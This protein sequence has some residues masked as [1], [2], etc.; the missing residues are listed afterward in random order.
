MKKLSL[1]MLVLSLLPVIGVSAYAS[2]NI[3]TSNNNQEINTNENEAINQESN[4]GNQEGESSDKDVNNGENSLSDDVQSSNQYDDPS[5]ATLSSTNFLI[6][7]SEIPPVDDI[8]DQVDPGYECL[9]QLGTTELVKKYGNV[10]ALNEKG[11]PGNWEYQPKLTVLLGGQEGADNTINGIGTF[12]V[13]FVLI[14][15]DDQGVELWGDSGD[16]RITVVPDSVALDQSHLAGLETKTD[17]VEL[18]TTELE[19]RMGNWN[20]E[21]SVSSIKYDANKMVTDLFG[22]KVIGAGNPS[23][24]SNL[25]FAVTNTSDLDGI[26]NSQIGEYKIDVALGLTRNNQVVKTL[27]LVVKEPVVDV[28]V[29]E[30]TVAPKATTNGS[31]VQTG[32]DNNIFIALLMVIVASTMLLMLRRFRKE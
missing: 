16:I 20:P 14:M 17:Y 3:D 27:T 22:A 31:G 5:K 30:N 29:V 1:L 4:Q 23:I 15:E 21:T 7:E 2:E 19:A 8:C 25:A 26:V 32:S 28:P 24:D 18:T 9:V 10:T 12:R 11:E 6:N 13:G